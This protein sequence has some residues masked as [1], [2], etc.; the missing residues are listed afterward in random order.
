[1]KACILPVLLLLYSATT[2]AQYAPQ[3][4]V[5]GSTAISSASPLFK[6]WASGCTI[7][8]GLKQIGNTASG[9][10]TAGDSSLALGMPDGSIVS[11]GDSGVAVLTFAAAIINGQG[12]D[13]AVFEN[14]FANPA[15]A[16]EA[17]LELAFVEVSSDGVNFTR[18]PAASLTQ[19]TLQIAAAGDYMNA[20]LLN[21]LA[22]KYVGTW[23][24]PFDLQELAGVSGLDI[25][26][27]TH[28]R[29]VDV[30]GSIGGNGS[31]DAQGNKIN[32]P[33]PTPF[34]GGGFDLDAV[35]VINQRSAAGVMAAGTEE[36]R[37][38]PNPVTDV[39]HMV[40]PAA[41]N[42]GTMII[43]D[44]TGRMVMQKSIMNKDVACSLSHLVPGLYY[45]TLRNTAGQLWVERFVRQ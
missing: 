34:A 27:I 11:L 25:N 32:D 4:T 28:V 13:F 35:G 36:V 30:I 43:T 9:Y 20:R 1:M 37:M 39:L 23:G 7:Q 18:F 3:A 22:G 44:A 19:D 33:F 21:N 24:T 38:Y 42:S 16:E 2:L 5:A 8:R 29:L 12:A 14:G 40:L 17:F 45:L 15:N 10:A 31:R 6:S 26:N 41:F